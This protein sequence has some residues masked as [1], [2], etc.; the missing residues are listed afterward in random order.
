MKRFL[1]LLVTLFCVTSMPAQTI[2]RLDANDV[3]QEEFWTTQN[4]TNLNTKLS[5]S[6]LTINYLRIGIPTIV[7]Q[8]GK[9]L[10]NNGSVFQWSTP[11]TGT[12]QSANTVFAGPTSGGAATPAFRSLVVGDVPD[13]SSLYISASS[14]SVTP[15][16]LQNTA[17]TAGDYTYA[18]FTVDAD[19]RLTAASSNTPVTAIAGTANQITLSAS[20]GSVTASLP[21]DVHIAGTMFIGGTS[22]LQWGDSGIGGSIRG[23][24]GT[25]ADGVFRF[26]DSAGGGSPAIILGSN[27]NT[28]GI[29]VKRSSTTFVLRVGDDSADA[30]L[31]AA[32]LTL[33]GVTANTLMYANGSKALGSVTLEGTLTLSS[34]TLSITAGSIDLTTKVTGVT[35]AANGGTGQ[36]TLAAAIS[37][38]TTASTGTIEI[39]P[40]TTGGDATDV[41]IK[42][43]DATT[44]ANLNGADASIKSGD[45]SGTGGSKVRVFTAQPGSSGT[46]TRTSTER[47]VIDHNGVTIENTTAPSGNPPAG[48]FHIYVDP[49]TN[50]LCAKGSSGTVT[51][52]AAP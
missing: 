50:E 10:S 35:P 12:T 41:V 26:G 8:S 22:S 42:G 43:A 48:A 4:L 5:A 39:G 18:S 30:S 31:S 44:G 52:L 3:G 28:A 2:Y 11:I 32:G 51:I 34:G 13:L 14:G 33:S 19:G 47:V 25:V 6:S 29:R 21:S 36:S 9:V 40:D 15:T 16:Y 45:S 46:T 1:L 17:V 37:A 7:G 27:S 49:G 38:L 20:T 24:L 23:F